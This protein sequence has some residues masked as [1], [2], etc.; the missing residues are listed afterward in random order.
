MSSLIT[1]GLAKV[2]LIISRGLGFAGFPILTPGCIINKE[3]DVLTLKNLAL[4]TTTQ[5]SKSFDA[6]TEL[7]RSLSVTT[8]L[9]LSLNVDTSATKT[10]EECRS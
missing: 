8:T 5:V 1:A 4:E 9:Q 6:T 2:Q 3:I 10:I 7:V